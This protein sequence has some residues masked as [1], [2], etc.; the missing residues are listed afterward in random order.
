MELCAERKTPLGETKWNQ[1]LYS[2]AWFALLGLLTLAAN[3]FQ[4]ELP[5][6]V[7][8]VIGA[9]C[10]CL[11]GRDL[12]PLMPVAVCCYLAPSGSNNP[13][14]SETSFF[15]SGG[16]YV[17]IV[18][19]VILA[20]ALIFRLATDKRI[21][22]RAL[23]RTKR[24]LLSGML[25]LGGAY[26]LAGAFSGY[27]FD[28]G[29]FN[30]LFGFLQFAAVFFLYFLMTACV[31]W[32]RAPRDYFAWLGIMMGFLLLGELAWI[33]ISRGVVVDGEIIRKRIITGWGHY[34]NI[35][36]ML[37]MAM[38][39]AFQLACV[40][41]RGWIWYLVGTAF[42]LGVFA[43]CSRN[44][45]LFGVAIYGLCCL[46]WLLRSRDRRTALICILAVVGGA[47][48]LLLL[49]RA[50]VVRLFWDMISRGAES[51][52]R[53]D[54]YRSAMEQFLDHPIFGGSFYP[55][56]YENEYAFLTVDAFSAFFPHRWHNTPLQI[57]ASCGVV[58]LAAY[59][60]HRIQTLRLLWKAP[61]TENLSI[62]LSVL[63]L[64]LTSLLDCHFFNIGPTL[65]YS[66]ALA[67]LEKKH[68]NACN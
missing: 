12:L 7:C 27:Y 58:G 64:L 23:I 56:E 54:M 34:N 25:L 41:K 18:L 24:K 37:L 28:R 5:V 20:A 33:Y 49:L 61:T 52:G 22:F 4:A 62:G 46:L 45:I 51:D 36:A 14:V 21:G 42:L 66:M 40:R 6:Y 1:F 59:S 17:L 43:T 57:L 16:G 39:F 30:L 10:V 50:Q 32:E 55:N 13:G 15:Y 31:D 53:I 47:L 68:E 48:A 8:L 60:V 9:V 35:G 2:P 26:V 11:W 29:G 67:F 65:V 19:A 44:S 3:V 63:A 38:P